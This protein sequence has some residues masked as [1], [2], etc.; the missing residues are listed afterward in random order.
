VI[1]IH[2]LGANGRMYIILSLDDCPY[3]RTWNSADNVKG[4]FEKK[5]CVEPTA[6]NFKSPLLRL[7][8]EITTNP[9]YLSRFSGNC[10]HLS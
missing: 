7:P 2:E 10:K 9:E 6:E 1:K 5:N 3:N 4:E 8:F